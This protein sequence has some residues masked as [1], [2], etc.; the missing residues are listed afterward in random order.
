MR[1]LTLLPFTCL[2][3]LLLVALSIEKLSGVHLLNKT[4]EE[5]ECDHHHEYPSRALFNYQPITTGI[6]F[7][8]FGMLMVPL[9]EADNG[10]ALY[11]FVKFSSP[12]STLGKHLDSTPKILSATVNFVLIKFWLLFDQ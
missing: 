2:P 12:Q 8:T 4:T 1:H 11:K 6:T 9:A 10:N 7:T 3:L 5:D